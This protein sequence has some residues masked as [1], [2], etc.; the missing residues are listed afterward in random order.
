MLA[1]ARLAGRYGKSAYRYSSTSAPSCRRLASRSMK[2]LIASVNAMA[3]SR[4]N[5]VSSNAC[6]RRISSF[7]VGVQ[8][9][10]SSPAVCWLA[11]LC[12]LDGSPPLFAPTRS[13]PLPSPPATSP[14]VPLVLRPSRPIDGL[15]VAAVLTSMLRLIRP[16]KSV[17]WPVIHPPASS[18]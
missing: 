2:S 3:S 1:N 11:P 4:G 16:C 12:C 15:C 10:A 14:S 8:R 18:G 5:G 9:L 17:S 6:N 13:P 7:C